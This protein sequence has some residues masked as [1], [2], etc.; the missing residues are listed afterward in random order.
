MIT[1]NTPYNY[2]VCVWWKVPEK[3]FNICHVF[4][5]FKK[6]QI[7]I[8]LPFLSTLDLLQYI[9]DKISVTKNPHCAGARTVPA[10]CGCG[11]HSN[12]R[13]QGHW[14]LKKDK[15]WGKKNF[16]LNFF[17]VESE[18]IAV[19]NHI[20]YRTLEK[21]MLVCINFGYGCEYRYGYKPL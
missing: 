9:Y 7:G 10:L 16:F 17:T 3:W 1:I 4:G 14:T 8:C 15:F 18:N 19:L 21:S 12:L 6:P 5:I 13:F 2:R 20:F 11:P